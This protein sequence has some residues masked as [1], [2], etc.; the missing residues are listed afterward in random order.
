MRTK[1]FRIQG[2]FMM[3]NAFQP[4][5][6]EL[7]AINEDDI[8]E[9]IYSEFGSKHGINRNKIVIEDIKEIS[10]DDVQDPMIKALIG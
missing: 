3:G 9:K 2:K 8:H 4:F 5:T 1:I 6:K 7:K 10:K